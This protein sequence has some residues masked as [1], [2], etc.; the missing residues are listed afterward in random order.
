MYHR[1][2]MEKVPV[3]RVVSQRVSFTV[4]VFQQGT[5]HVRVRCSLHCL[6]G[7]E[8]QPALASNII[9]WDNH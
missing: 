5:R 2:V 9:L 1:E 4:V 3:T 8:Q 7:V 6:M